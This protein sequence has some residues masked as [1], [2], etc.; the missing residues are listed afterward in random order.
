MTG[1]DS[2]QAAGIGDDAARESGS[3]VEV[4]EAGG[5][6]GGGGAR[7]VVLMVGGQV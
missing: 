4:G 2:V 7:Q 1:E 3:L 6:L 5:G